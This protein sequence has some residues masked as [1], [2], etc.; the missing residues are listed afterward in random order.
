M[1]LN[2]HSYYSLRYGT[3]SPEKLVEKL[4]YKGYDCAVLT[5]INNSSGFFEFLKAAGELGL[6]ALAGIEF[7][8]GDRLLFIGIARNMEGFRELNE[9][10]TAHNL[11]GDGITPGGLNDVTV[12]YPY[13]SREAHTLA[14][15]EFLGVRQNQLKLLRK[16]GFQDLSR[17][18]ILHPVT[19]EDEP[20]YLLHRQLRAIDNNLLLSQ[21]RNEQV[22][23]PG[24]NIPERK[25]LLA[26]YSQ[27]PELINNTARLLSECSFSFSFRREGVHHWNK[28]KRVFGASGYDDKYQLQQLA[29][30][31]CE[32]R[33][34]KAHKEALLRVKKELAVIDELQFNANFLITWDIIRYSKS[35]GYYHVGRGSGANSIVAY[36]LGITDVCP[37]QL[38]LYFERFLNPKR[39]VPPDFDIDFSWKDRDD[40][41]G[42]ILKK[43]GNRHAA[44]LGA[45]STFRDRSIVRELGK[46][47]GLPKKEIDMLVH[48]PEGA[49]KGNEITALILNVSRHL[50]KDFPNLRTVHAGGVLISEL[51]ITSY[52][53]LDLPPKGFPT[54]Q[55][56]MY[57]AEDVGFEKFD[58]LSQRGIGHIRECIEIVK[59]NQG[60][61]VDITDPQALMEDSTVRSR[62][63]SGD[64]VG[65]FYIESPA[66]RGLLRKLGC[67][68]YRTL[69]AASSIIRPGVAQSGM[70]REY[71]HRYHH[72]EDI[73]HLHPVIEEQL[74]ETFGVMVYQED[75]LKV[76]HH[77]A[78]LDLG[79]SDVLRRLMSGKTRQRR[80]LD[81]ITEKFFNNCRERGY[82]EE[83]SREV[84]RQIESFAGFSFSK[85]HSASYAVESYQSLY[86]KAHYPLEFM[87]AVINNFG[88][89]Y[90]TRV[91]VSE[92]RKAGARIHLPCVNE[93]SY[94]TGITGRDIYLGFVHI[95]NLDAELARHIELERSL[96]GNYLSLDDFISRVHPGLDQLTVLIRIGAL[97]FTGRN[98]KQLLWDAHLVLGRK[99]KTNVGG[100]NL[101]EVA[102][103]QYELPAF[104][105][106]PL[107]DAYDEME[108]L[109]FPV[110]TDPFD[111]LQHPFRGDICAEDMHR[112]KGTVVRMMGHLVATKYIRTAKNG[113]ICFG[114]FIDHQSAFF[115]TVH[116]SQALGRSPF[117]G[118]GTYLIQGTVSEEFGHHTLEVIQMAKMPVRPDPRAD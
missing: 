41:L 68:D 35:K 116:F 89:F 40:V 109:G 51:P 118:E 20:G 117:K 114:T 75:V 7:R 90:N 1:L 71:I 92:A 67:Q 22:A 107:E 81:E 16:A 80:L 48:E 74:Q 63:K 99:Q 26:A 57:T 98:K 2:V 25:A 37:L 29:I 66:M 47:Y 34:G 15:H 105:A 62:L 111:L 64:T 17:C 69:V 13:G 70:M 101:F 39:S 49:G 96:C 83:I 42:Y 55:I 45:T 27:F 54:A 44:L 38:D 72:P 3:I 93:S 46:V 94:T 58:V 77:F 60:I 115:D 31:G 76:C 97:R 5:D 82:P 65:C 102:V 87:T 19:F 113:T 24:E 23:G 95:Q 6:K 53:A 78:G 30:E 86:L 88:G 110:T 12:I 61:S 52:T 50:E 79:D 28:N 108:L 112:S 91:Y 59:K 14:D 106:D 36:C 8:D 84:W 4:L 100:P 21:L 104:S 11:E 18:V 56:D 103:K 85:A 9:L 33:Y 43:Y 32:F 10:L 73:R